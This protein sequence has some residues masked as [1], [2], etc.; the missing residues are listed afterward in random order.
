MNHLKSR[1][2]STFVLQ[3]LVSNTLYQYTVRDDTEGYL[4]T[5]LKPQHKT[6]KKTELLITAYYIKRQCLEI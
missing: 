1:A 5:C 3:Y 4:R 6:N 2:I